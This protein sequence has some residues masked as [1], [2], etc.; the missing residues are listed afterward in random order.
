MQDAVHDTVATFTRS[1][2]LLSNAHDR[3]TRNR[4]AQGVGELLGLS[5]SGELRPGDGPAKLLIPADTLLGADAAA[6]GV[7]HDRDLWGGVAPF[8]HVA[9]KAVSHGL[10]RPGAAA[11]HGWN[12]ALGDALGDAVLT[13]FS[14]FSRDDALEAGVALLAQ[15]PVRVKQ[16]HAAGGRGQAVAADA[17]AL[18]SALDALSDAALA[19]HG[20]V[21]EENLRDVET[22]SVGTTVLG[23]RRI[24]YWGVQRFIAA[25]NGGEIY[26][27][28]DLDAAQ[29]DLD[30]LLAFD[31][32][33]K[34]RRAIQMARR[35]DEAVF[36]AYPGL[37]A[38]RRNYDVIFGTDAKG[39]ARA[40]VLEQ[41]WR[42]G[43]ASGAELAAM[44]AFERDPS[45]RL[46]RS[47][48]MEIRDTAAQVPPDATLYYRDV[49]PVAGP[50][51]KFA[52]LRP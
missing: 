50:I 24:A 11:P 43:G 36:A 4:L 30:D 7:H 14:A 3:A 18:A 32:P 35:Y 1:D 26:T 38:S 48:T 44:Q 17:K 23:R 6:L 40:G 31:L 49:D 9:T 12:P 29:G 39:Q 21:L 41:S 34:A 47:F 33:D 46:V 37:F 25:R 13:G 19:T 27:G 2:D 20:V 10:V 42:V 5:F 16:V 22:Y 52:G 8:A 45:P 51:T 15:G 28:S